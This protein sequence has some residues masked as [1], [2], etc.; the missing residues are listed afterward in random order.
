[1][2]A[3]QSGSIN[4]GCFT[5]EKYRLSWRPGSRVGVQQ[6][7]H[8]E[9][10]AWIGMVPFVSVPYTLNLALPNLATPLNTFPGLFGTGR[11]IVRVI[12]AGRVARPLWRANTQLSDANLRLS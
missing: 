9:L 2:G 4:V 6:K 5:W 12:C 10:L 3:R 8:G 11:A 7:T 1:M